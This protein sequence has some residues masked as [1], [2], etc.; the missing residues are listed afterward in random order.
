MI[1][2]W[3]K[4]PDGGKKSGVTGYFLI[5]FKKG[6]SLVLLHF[7]K[8]TREAF[9]EHAF[10]AI[11]IWLKG[12]VREHHLWGEPKDFTAGNIKLT[13]RSTFHKIEALK[14]TWAFSIRGPWVDRW[15]E[16]RD[17]RYVTLTHGR[18]EVTTA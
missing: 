2:F 9:H 7:D 16:Y 11:T 18:V 17:G 1:R 12:C 13:P 5:E 14:D 3:K 4:A 15:R 8:G 10:N 6:F